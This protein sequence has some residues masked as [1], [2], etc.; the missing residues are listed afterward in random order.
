MA[1]HLFGD[2]LEVYL[3]NTTDG[4]LINHWPAQQMGLLQGGRLWIENDGAVR[5]LDITRDTV[6]APISGSQP[7]FSADGRTLAIF[8]GGQI[9]LID[10]QQGRRLQTIEGR[11]DEIS[12]IH[13]APDGKTLGA[14][15]LVSSC[16]GCV[17]VES[18]LAFWHTS[19]GSRIFD[20]EGADLP[21][22]LSFSPGG[23]SILLAQP[24]GVQVFST[25]D[26]T[27]LH[28]LTGFSSG[29]AGI[30][31]APD[32]KEFAIGKGLPF[33]TAEIWR[34]ADGLMER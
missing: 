15:T 8:T 12:G 24:D 25:E 32:G 3:Y 29:I 22:L 11:Y 20:I 34:I 5:V 2:P 23:E 31:F 4:T 9:E 19:D 16:A 18:T 17:E 33:F 6:T 27:Q 26:G 30:A 1:I 14:L 28:A 21:F 10:I 7:D 13:F